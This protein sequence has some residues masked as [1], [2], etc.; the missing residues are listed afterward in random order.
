M[1]ALLLAAAV[2][3]LLLRQYRSETDNARALMQER[4]RAVLEALSAGIRTQGWMCHRRTERVGQ[5]FGEL[6]GRSGII[7]LQLRNE[8]GKVLA[9]SGSRIPH[10]RAGST[11]WSGSGLVMTEEVRFEGCPTQHAPTQGCGAGP[12]G[13]RCG[14]GVFVL[15]A[16]LDTRRVAR[17]KRRQ[18]I[19]F[20]VAGALIIA[21]IGFGAWLVVSRLRQGQLR[22]ELVL[23]EERAGQSE[24]LA[25]LG[26]GLAHETKNPLGVVRGLAQAVGALPTADADVKQKASDIVDEV[27]RTVG[28]I[29]AF[30][31]LARP[32]EAKRTTVALD[33]FFD[34]FLPLLRAEGE[35]KRVR[36]DYEPSGLRILADEQ[37]LRGLLLNL[38]SNGLQACGAEG[39][40]SITA[41]R[42]GHTA[43]LCVRDDGCGIAAED[44]PEVTKPYFTRFDNGCG[45]GLPICEQTARAHGWT[46]RIASQP[47]AG[48]TV[49]V[50]SIAL[51]G[52]RHA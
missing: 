51:A 23:A 29:N 16:V 19:N 11:R 43:T 13:T 35:G 15:T 17:E 33:P 38:V 21:A 18:A 41:E 8:S 25:Q 20:T 22:T 37:L 32:A 47:D 9:S 12:P 5:V 31:R 44:L 50:T 26:A 40:V 36:I 45:L 49:T 46:M 28:Q 27:D 34:G 39:H 24:T 10:L 14:G 3:V 6:T 7:G 1:L 30:L 2:L 52:G 48:T 4:G 42:T